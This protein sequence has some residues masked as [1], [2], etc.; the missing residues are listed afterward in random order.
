MQQK[1]ITATAGLR[2]LAAMLQTGLSGV[3][4]HFPLRE[5]FAPLRCG[6]SSKLF[7]HLFIFR[8]AISE[9][10]HCGCV[11]HRFYSLLSQ[12]CFGG[13]LY[14]SVGKSHNF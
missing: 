10:G 3:T 13:P 11:S 9:T 6:L 14:F 1:S 5:N 2:Q 7:D 8:T 12:C 4:V